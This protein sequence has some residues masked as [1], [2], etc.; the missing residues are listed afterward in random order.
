[1]RGERGECT[2]EQT[3]ALGWARCEVLGRIEQKGTK[4]EEIPDLIF[5][6]SKRSH[7]VLSIEAFGIGDER[8]AEGAEYARGKKPRVSNRSNSDCQR[9]RLK[10]PVIFERFPER[11]PSIQSGGK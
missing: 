5:Q 11:S 10:V 4:K 8:T 3:G 7:G 1:M 6:I 2:L 9:V